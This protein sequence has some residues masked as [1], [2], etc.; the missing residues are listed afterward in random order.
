[1][2]IKFVFKFEQ[3]KGKKSAHKSEE[4]THAKGETKR[5]IKAEVTCHTNKLRTTP[6]RLAD[7]N[8]SSQ[9][10]HVP[11]EERSP[12]DILPM[13]HISNNESKKCVKNSFLDF[14]HN[15]LDRY[16]E[17]GSKSRAWLESLP[18]AFRIIA[19][20]VHESCP[21]FNSEGSKTEIAPSPYFLLCPTTQHE[22]K[23]LT[24]FN[25]NQVEQVKQS[26][27]KQE[28]H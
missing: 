16:H 13:T 17:K 12:Q 7:I 11:T 10:Y 2:K 4:F 20:R 9:P 8:L 22:E 27:E 24:K 19:D 23:I 1:M 18:S 21:Y 6:P 3:A 28:L 26:N 5:G 14:G 25:C 15:H